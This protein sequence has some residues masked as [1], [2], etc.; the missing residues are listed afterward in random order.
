MTNKKSYSIISIMSPPREALTLARIQAAVTPLVDYRKAPYAPKG[1][2]KSLPHLATDTSGGFGIVGYLVDETKVRKAI[3][4][5]KGIVRDNVRS[6]ETARPQLEVDLVK[7]TKNFN[8]YSYIAASAGDLEKGYMYDP[9]GAENHPHIRELQIALR[10]IGVALIPATILL[11]AEAAAESV[12]GVGPGVDLKTAVLSMGTA[13]VGGGLAHK[14]IMWIKNLIEKLPIIGDL[15]AEG[16]MMR[17]PV[18]A[19]PLHLRMAMGVAFE[20]GWDDLQKIQKKGK[21]KNVNGVAVVGKHL[22]D[23]A[24]GTYT[25]L[26]RDNNPKK[27]INDDA[28]I[29]TENRDRSEF[30]TLE[31]TLLFAEIVSDP[32]LGLMLIAKHKPN[33][34]I[35]QNILTKLSPEITSVLRSIMETSIRLN[36]DP[37][38]SADPNNK[39]VIQALD[40]MEIVQMM[41][42]MVN[43]A[44]NH[45]SAGEKML[46]PGRFGI[47]KGHRSNKSEKLRETSFSNISQKI[48]IPI[49]GTIIAA[50]GE[51]PPTFILSKFKRDFICAMPP[52]GMDDIHM[53]GNPIPEWI[54]SKPEAE[55]LKAYKNEVGTASWNVIRTLLPLIKKGVILDVEREEFI[56]SL[57]DSWT[58]R[59]AFKAGIPLQSSMIKFF[60]GVMDQSESGLNFLYGE[61]TN[62]IDKNFISQLAK[63]PEDVVGVV[64][65]IIRSLNKRRG[66]FSGKTELVGATGKTMKQLELDQIDKMGNALLYAGNQLIET[67]KSFINSIPANELSPIN[68]ATK[69]WIA[70]TYALKRLALS[71]INN[72][73]DAKADIESYE[74]LSEYV[75]QIDET[76]SSSMQELGNNLFALWQNQVA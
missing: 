4:R 74:K 17:R 31:R 7:A 25:S 55:A 36:A 48:A 72:R 54:A 18:E 28:R 50:R 66:K 23:L 65:S 40:E 47:S 43:L 41:E 24:I 60:E 39:R 69:L 33:D 16:D 64:D 63:K 2:L 58:K 56:N 20:K 30:A 26:N 22:N 38:V 32:A 3:K 76:L 21:E 11:G 75:K 71:I 42:L 45:G 62:L 44:F 34:S 53:G 15:V 19:D 67:G 70:R 1:I 49:I 12:L 13:I 59:N 61:F 37:D 27:Y 8:V 68:E 6:D 9:E 14:S 57:L 73:M 5:H 35:F 51:K 46:F 10:H 29:Q 52:V